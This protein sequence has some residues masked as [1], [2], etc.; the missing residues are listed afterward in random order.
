M[1]INELLDS[2]KQLAG[3][4]KDQELADILE[5]YPTVISNM[6]SGVLLM[7]AG[8]II[9]IHEAFGIPVAE[10]KRL[11]GVTRRV[12]PLAQVTAC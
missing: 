1:K 12:E 6:R 2:L 10:I 5:I 3:V 4:T 9:K 7:G 8:Y 11:A